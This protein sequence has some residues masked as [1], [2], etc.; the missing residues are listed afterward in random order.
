MNNID[1]PDYL[2]NSR[3]INH[4]SVRKLLHHWAVI[5]VGAVILLSLT[6]LI[7]N[8]IISSR[9]EV[10]DEQYIPMGNLSR[11][12]ERMVN[13]LAEHKNR[14]IN[15]QS[16]EELQNY[17]GSRDELHRQIGEH[18]Q[19][20][21]TITPSIKELQFAI[22][23]LEEKFRSWFDQQDRLLELLA[24]I[25]PRDLSA[26]PE[27]RLNNNLDLVQVKTAMDA[28]EKDL[29]D[30]LERLGSF[31]AEKM[32]LLA[33]QSRDLS[34]IN[35]L[36][37]VT[38]SL[39]VISVIMAGIAQV[40]FRIDDPLQKLSAAMHEL[41]SGNLSRRMAINEDVRDE[42][43]VMAGNFNQFAQRNEALFDEVIA[44]KNAL[45]DS[46]KRV[47]AILENALVGIAH[48]RDGRIVAVNRKFE[49]IFGYK[50]DEIQ[51]MNKDILYP[52]PHVHEAI[53]AAAS[54]LLA[55]DETYQGEWKMRH[56]NGTIFW[57]AVSA[58]SISEKTR[59]EGIIWLF[60]D[61]TQRKQSEEDLLH[62]ANFDSLTELPNRS[63]FLDRLEQGFGRTKRQNNLL[64]LLYIDL[65]RFKKVNDSFGHTTGDALLIAVAD[66]LGQCIRNSDTVSRLG[67]DE[68]TIILPEIQDI[69]DAG[70]VAEKIITVMDESFTIEGHEINISPSIGVSI[71]P[72]DAGDIESLMKNADSAMYHA[73]SMG[74]N[75]YQYYTQA[76][77]AEARQRLDRENRLRH[78]VEYDQLRLYYQP[79]VDAKTLAV[80]GYEAL[81]RWQ[82][83]DSG[84]VPP[85]QFVPLLEDTGL[86]VPVGEWILQRACRDVAK[87]RAMNKDFKSVSINLSARQFVDNTLVD[88]IRLILEETGTSPAY[89]VIEITE[90][91]MMTET[92]RSLAILTELSNLGFQLSLDDF[93]TGYSSLAYLKQFPINAIKIDRSFV[94][95]LE[96][97]NSDA[98]ICEAIITIGR[99]LGLK[100]VAEGVETREQFIYMRD[101]GCDLIQGYYFGRPTPIDNILC[102]VAEDIEARV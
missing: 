32:K 8:D 57:C 46:E 38:V 50:R 19:Q 18:L 99:Q 45:E 100:V 101:R 21:T 61:I 24:G 20:L 39:L 96:H 37:N 29:H 89:I 65:D 102:E 71:Y 95:G 14:L 63:L 49:E 76:M 15:A 26:T 9:H 1:L 56:R 74:R 35:W 85:D 30:S 55:N 40:I 79:Q 52:S 44:A 81:I 28:T 2:K 75:N 90:T 33:G 25:I 3:F 97:N 70:K 93:G 66:R 22:P 11:N 80:T 58:K 91:I 47:R 68:F 59:E 92:E 53:N 10:L 87:L 42:F 67:G 12:L 7:T 31:S 83:A 72:D 86:I 23:S 69:S 84:L 27:G 64:G 48:V 36:V 16:L 88:R 13:D 78:A 62:L 54:K 6:A 94:H 77:N 60:E 98:A 51:G 5:C 82:D 73:K 43:T 41:S 17:R 34:Q 4:L